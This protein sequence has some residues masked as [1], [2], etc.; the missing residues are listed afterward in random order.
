VS[1]ELSGVISQVQINCAKWEINGSRE[2][3]NRDRLDGIYTVTPRGIMVVGNTNQL[4]NRNKINSFERNRNAI[5]NPEVITFDELY[6]RARFIVYNNQEPLET[7]DEL[8][9]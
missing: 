8:P 5:Q 3:D 2:D 4:N 1:N 9:F 6:Q 7:D